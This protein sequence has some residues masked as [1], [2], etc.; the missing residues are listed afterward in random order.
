MPFA[1]SIVAGLVSMAGFVG[2]AQAVVYG[3]VEFPSGAVSFADQ[4]WV[5]YSTVDTNNT[6][7]GTPGPI[8]QNA[9]NAT[10][11]PNYT[12]ASCTESSCSYVSLGDGGTLI[13]QF[14]DNLLTGSGNSAPD[15]W[16]FEIGPDVEDTFVW[17]SVNGADW[18]AVG[19]VGGATSGV[20][21]DAYGYGIDSMFGWVK[22]QDDGAKDDQSGITVGA[23]IDAV[24]AISTVRVSDPPPSNGVPLPGTLGLLGLGMLAGAWRRRSV[25]R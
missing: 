23:D 10:G 19:S 12:G 8:Y 25:R 7:N 4:A 18:L 6:V 9:A 20:D 1:K 17:I 11:V 22:L 15:L 13:L 5:D 2:S 24:G 16:V 14:T 3:G 21:I